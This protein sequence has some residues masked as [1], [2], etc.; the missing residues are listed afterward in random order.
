MQVNL[1]SVKVNFER[2]EK[3]GKNCK[4]L[5]ILRMKRGF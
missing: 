4:K 5:N 1:K 3:K 2:V